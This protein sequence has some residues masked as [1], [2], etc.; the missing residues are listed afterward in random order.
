MLPRRLR[1]GQRLPRARGA[2]LAGR[3][4]GQGQREPRRLRAA[5]HVA[6][7]PRRAHGRLSP[8]DEGPA[9]ALPPPRAGGGRRRLRRYR[10]RHGPARAPGRGGAH[11]LALLARGPRAHGEGARRARHRLRPARGHGRIPGRRRQIHGGRLH[12]A[13]ARRY[14]RRRAGHERGAPPLRQYR[15]APGEGGLLLRRQI[16]PP[17]ARG[18]TGRG[19]PPRRVQGPRRRAGHARRQADGRGRQQRAAPDEG[20]ALSLLPA[21]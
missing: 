6:L 17:A 1:A 11:S 10:P 21:S 16:R 9:A 14:A 12:G 5:V 8:R 4:H 19:R 7:E 20:H 15:A 2:V 18:H 13:G 3:G